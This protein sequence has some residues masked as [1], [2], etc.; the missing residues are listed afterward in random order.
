[1]ETHAITASYI[2]NLRE[3]KNDDGW[4]KGMKKPQFTYLVNPEQHRFEVLINE[5]NFARGGDVR[6]R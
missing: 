6:R 1:V 5:L 3:K 2:A 4:N